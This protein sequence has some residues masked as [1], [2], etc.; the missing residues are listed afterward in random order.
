MLLGVTSVGFDGCLYWH[1]QHPDHLPALCGIN[2]TRFPTGGSPCP[3]MHIIHTDFQLYFT[4][5]VHTVYF[6]APDRPLY[7]L[8]RW[9]RRQCSRNNCL[10]PLLSC[11]FPFRSRLPSTTATIYAFSVPTSPTL[12]FNFPG[13]VRDLQEM[14]IGTATLSAVGVFAAG[15]FAQNYN[16]LLIVC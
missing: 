4:S 9:R 16:G 13:L 7:A 2:S 10:S 15:L 5:L 6:Q 3:G 1:D 11:P 14:L 8:Y 12:T